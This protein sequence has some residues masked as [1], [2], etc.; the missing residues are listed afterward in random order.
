MPSTD[1]LLSFRVKPETFE[2]LEQFWRNN[3]KY[4]NRAAAAKELLEE[5]LNHR[6]PVPPAEPRPP[7]GGS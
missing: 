6:M 1:P 4:P 5:C 2:R 3:R 7:Q